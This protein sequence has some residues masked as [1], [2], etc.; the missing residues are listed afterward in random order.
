MQITLVNLINTA[1]LAH[2]KV[3]SVR[4]HKVHACIIIM[5][6]GEGKGGEYVQIARVKSRLLVNIALFAHIRIYECARLRCSHYHNANT[7]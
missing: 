2:L 1:L 7:G 6:I 5:L 4:M 3:Y